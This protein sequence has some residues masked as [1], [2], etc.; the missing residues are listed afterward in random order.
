MNNNE[1]RIKHL[2]G[3]DVARGPYFGRRWPI[4]WSATAKSLRNT[5]LEDSKVMCFVITSQEGFFSTLSV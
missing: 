5:G 4:R 3:P 1:G 2:G